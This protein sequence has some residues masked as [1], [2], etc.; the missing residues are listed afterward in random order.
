MSGGHQ[1]PKPKPE[2]DEASWKGALQKSQV[3]SWLGR[4]L[5]FSFSLF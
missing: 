5:A 2:G 4:R 1:I 3:S